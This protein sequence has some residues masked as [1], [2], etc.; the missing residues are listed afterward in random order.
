M[1]FR[2]HSAIL[3]I[4]AGALF[5]PASIAVTSSQKAIESLI[6]KIQVCSRAKDVSCLQ[7]HVADPQALYIVNR[8]GK[9]ELDPGFREDAFNTR[10]VSLYTV[11]V[12][13]TY[14]YKIFMTSTQT[15]EVV[16]FNTGRAS[17]DDSYAEMIGTDDFLQC[18]VSLKQ[19][20]W[21]LGNSACGYI[22]AGEFE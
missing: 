1:I 7:N 21:K 5:A 20:V 11:S 14:G 16:F 2:T 10:S 3:A 9:R 19:G 6:T 18:S 17:L 12:G 4:L 15:A 22:Y 8:D 13:E